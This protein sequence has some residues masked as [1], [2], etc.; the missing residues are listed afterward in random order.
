MAVSGRH[1]RPP[2]ILPQGRTA[3]PTTLICGPRNI[4]SY[5]SIHTS[6]RSE[7]RAISFAGSR[8]NIDADLVRCKTWL[9]AIRSPVDA[10]YGLIGTGC[11]AVTV[12]FARSSQP[13]I[14]SGFNLYFT[15]L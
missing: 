5:V 10:P 4:S 11:S 15:V 3:R 6:N 7:S 13:Q 1:Q 2:G 14:V 8:D 12:H 9:D